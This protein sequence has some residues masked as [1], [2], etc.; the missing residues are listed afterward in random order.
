MANSANTFTSLKPMYKEVY[1]SKNN[2]EDNKYYKDRFKK[3]HSLF[4]QRRK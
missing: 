1:S 3:L 4:K 2:K